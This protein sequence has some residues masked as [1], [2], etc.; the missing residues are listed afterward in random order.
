MI[1]WGAGWIPDAPLTLSYLVTGMNHIS[2]A[3]SIYTETSTFLKSIVCTWNNATQSKLLLGLSFFNKT[4]LFLTNFTLKRSLLLLM[5]WKFFF[6]CL[7][8]TFMR[9]LTFL[10]LKAFSGLMTH[11][12]VDANSEFF[13]LLCTSSHIFGVK[14]HHWIWHFLLT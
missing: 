13:M 1:L 2:Y 4:A 12:N 9:V 8:H 14:R 11:W 6:S 3:R 7:R 5:I 10:V